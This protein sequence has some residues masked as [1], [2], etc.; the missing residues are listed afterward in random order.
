MPENCRRFTYRL[1]P[2]PKKV[3]LQQNRRPHQRLWLSKLGAVAVLAA[4]ALT[5]C[6]FPDRHDA[7]DS[8]SKA[9]RAMPGVINTDGRYDTSF[10]GGAHYYLTVT[11]SGASSD[12]QGAAVAR[13]FVKQIIDADFKHFDVKLDLE[14]Q[15]PGAGD[16][17]SRLEV[18][19][20][21][22]DD[23]HT[24]LSAD[25]VAEGTAWW[26]DIARSPAIAGVSVSLPLDNSY[27]DVNPPLRVALSVDADDV[28]LAAL[29]R[30][31]PQ[32]NSAIWTVGLPSPKPHAQPRS[33][34][35]RGR[36]PDHRSRQVWQRLVDQVGP[37][38]TATATT[39]IPPKNGRTPTT[40]KIALTFDH[41]RENDLE[42]VAR[43]VTPLLTELP[44]PV[45]FQL[46]TRVMDPAS[47]NVVD[48]DLTV[49]VGGCTQDGESQG[50]NHPALEAELRHAYERC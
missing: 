20:A 29:I 21:F 4:L 32:L 46:N 48:Q 39:Q 45:R 24:G 2:H 23:V 37:F 38:D 13:T 47:G 28:S 26:L 19:Y 6:G 42:R 1:L 33:Y 41:G 35:S 12:E 34:D 5:S 25:A 44:G 10:A 11:L 14:Y 22:D 40:V 9:I 16:A 49:T 50:D 31:H 18:N 8:I 43:D 27:A 15:R 36:F 3:T 7:A 17:T 30:H